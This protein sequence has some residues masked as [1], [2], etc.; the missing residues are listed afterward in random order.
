MTFPFILPAEAAQVWNLN[1]QLQGFERLPPDQQR[2]ITERSLQALYHWAVEHSPFWRDQLQEAGGCAG[3]DALDVLSRLPVLTRADV[4]AHGEAISCVQALP[5]N[6]CSVAQS[7]G[8]TGRPVRVYKHNA[9]FRLRYLSFAWRCTQWHGLDVS[10]PILRHSVRVQDGMQPNWGPPEAWFAQTGPLILS[11]SIDR[12]VSEMY[13]PI[14]QHQPAYLVA[15]ASVAHALALHALE[16]HP[17]A[18]PQLEAILSTGE[19][20]TDTLRTD[21]QRAFGA[22][23]INRYSCEEVGWLALQCPR[24]DHLHVL[25]ANVHLEIVDAQGR[26]CGVGEPGRVLVTALHSEAMPLIRYDVGD[27]AEW[28]PP[29][30]CGLSLP[31]LRRIWGREREFVRTPNGEYRY[32]AILAE[33]FAAI[34]PIRDM[35]FRYHPTN[36]LLRFEVV[37]D[38]P[39]TPSQQ[40]ALRGKIGQIL[41]FECPTDLIETAQINWGPTDKRLSFAVVNA[42]WQGNR[43]PTP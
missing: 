33:E 42:P 26:P 2:D 18:R 11:R 7:T 37:A 14:V 29:C 19:T 3:A 32:V 1:Q 39:L 25:T 10:R 31:V 23:V 20:V 38:A 35:R 36:P 34:A 28:G 12:D 4:Q 43:L 27:I 40:A 8:S 9:P 5:A 13:Q 16:H 17:H 21:C 6:S 15:N 24:H 30:D 41:G 22:R